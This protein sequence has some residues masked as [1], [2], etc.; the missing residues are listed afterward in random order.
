MRQALALLAGV[1]AL[2]AC[3]TAHQGPGAPSPV[4]ASTSA[5]PVTPSQ[6]ACRTGLNAAWSLNAPLASHDAAAVDSAAQKAAGSLTAAADAPY[7]TVSDAVRAAVAQEA[8]AIYAVG[9]AVQNIEYGSP[10]E[11][12][13]SFMSSYIAQLASDVQAL[14]AACR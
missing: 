5:G 13:W 3:G 8:G 9:A 11:Y 1:A 12:T 7:G 6:A 14:A 10:G 2:T 4:P